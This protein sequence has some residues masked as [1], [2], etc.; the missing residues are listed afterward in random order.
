MREATSPL[1]HDCSGVRHRFFSRTD[2]ALDVAA[3]FSIAPECLLGLEQIHS[4]RAIAVRGK[5]ET[6]RA[7]G[8]ATDCPGLAL[9]IS[10]ADCVPVLLADGKAGVVGALHAGWRG[11]LAGICEATAAVMESL[12]ARASEMRA[13]LGPSISQQC[14]EVDAPL[15]DA[16][17]QAGESERA[18]RFFSRTSET[19][20]LLDLPGYVAARLES[21]GIAHVE[22]IEHCTYRDEVRYYSYRRAMHRGEAHRGRQ[23]S[24]IMLEGK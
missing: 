16:F 23:L 12:G 20:G 17:A 15:L 5:G 13:A 11:A 18:Q 9:S 6:E 10:T 4:A 19:H 1:L 24:A 2:N 22:N 3:S 21:I 8:M 14:Y 7:D